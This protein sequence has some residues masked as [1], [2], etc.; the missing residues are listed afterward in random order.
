MA[1]EL[2]LDFSPNSFHELAMDFYKSAIRE[3]LFTCRFGS[4]DDAYVCD[5]IMSDIIGL[6]TKELVGM[7]EEEILA[8]TK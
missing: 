6:W 7:S 4:D 2:S 3:P 1:R 8:M 5:G